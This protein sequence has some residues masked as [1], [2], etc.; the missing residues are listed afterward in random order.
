MTDYTIPI[1]PQHPTLKE[2]MCIRVGLEGSVIKN[3]NVRMGYTHKGIEKV[4]EGKNPDSA[5]YTAQRICGICSAAHENAY[6]KTVENILGFQPEERVILLRTLMM[7]LERIHSHLLWLGTIC[8]EIGYETL[9]MFFWRE[10]EKIIDIFEKISGGRVHHNFNK[11][12]TVRYDLQHGDDKFIL[13]RLE[14]V[15]KTIVPYVPEIKNDN[16]IKSRLKGVG[17]ISFND[18]KRFCLIGPNARASGVSS[19]IRKIDPPYKIYD[20]FD[21]DEIILDNGDS[22]DRTLVR[23]KE[24]LESIKIIKQVFKVLPETKIPKFVPTTIQ[25]GRG[26]GRVE[27]PRGELFYYLDFRDNKIF[28]AKMRTPTFGYLKVFEKIVIDERIG[29]VPVLVGSLDPCF[30]CLER[31]MV[32]KDGKTEILN[33]R[34]FRRKYVCTK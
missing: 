18:A 12:K 20:R 15:K 33:E 22:F 13:K 1:G 17:V 6:T 21:F 7:E 10:R 8:H 9:F 23:L 19:D 24:V 34:D 3:A 25:D 28:R 27:A 14:D 29:D 31:V 4:L 2:P 26:V 11:I 30:S 32:V 5:L 16:V